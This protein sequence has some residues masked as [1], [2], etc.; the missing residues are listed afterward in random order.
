MWKQ[1][2]YVVLIVEAGHNSFED[3]QCG[4]VEFWNKKDLFFFFAEGPDKKFGRLASSFGGTG[5]KTIDGKSGF[6]QSS[7]HEGGVPF[8][9]FVLR[10]VKIT[11]IGA[12]SAAFCMS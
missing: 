7:G 6:D 2:D 9:S 12:V 4:V 10:A 5:Y 3:I 1:G 8:A 11:P